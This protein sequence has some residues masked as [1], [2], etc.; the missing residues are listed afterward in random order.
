MGSPLA[1]VLANFFMGHYERL[2][3]EKY[4][5]TQVRI[6]L[7]QIRRCCFQNS[8]DADMSFRYLNKCHPNI[9]STMETETDGKL[10]F[11]DVLLSKQRSSN[12]ECSCV[13]SVF[14]KK[15]YTGLLTNLYFSFTN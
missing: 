11:L 3:L 4:T 10:P 7:S 5:G 12:N 1:P 9:K 13:T 8:H 15:T 2:W 6:R 14:R